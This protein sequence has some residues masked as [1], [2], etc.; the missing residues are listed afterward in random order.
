M[1]L[2]GDD[3]QRIAL[4][5]VDQPV[6]GVYAH[7]GQPEAAVLQALRLAHGGGAG[8][9]GAPLDVFDE[10]VDP[11]QGLPVLGLPPYVVVPGGIAPDLPHLRL[12]QLVLGR[13][14]LEHGQVDRIHLRGEFAL[15]GRGRGHG[16]GEP[17]VRHELPRE[18]VEHRRGREADVGG[19]LLQLALEVGVEPDV[20][21]ACRHDASQ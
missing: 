5:L 11:L 6:R 8:L 18:H 20:E 21:R 17:A 10:L 14:A 3:E 7:A 12:D 4:D 2:A 13:V 9:A 1:P 16:E 15:G 19:H